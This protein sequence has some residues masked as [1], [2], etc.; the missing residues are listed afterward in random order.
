[1]PGSPEPAPPPPGPLVDA[2]MNPPAA[3]G[4]SAPGLDEVPPEFDWDWPDPDCGCPP[5]LAG[6]TYEELDA[7]PA[8]TPARYREPAW[9]IEP[10]GP[11]P[12]AQPAS[13]PSPA[14]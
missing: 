12:S 4:D 5:E 6:L 11:G 14:R 3:D 13:S 2:P 8:T 7:L 1:M 9:P 10:P